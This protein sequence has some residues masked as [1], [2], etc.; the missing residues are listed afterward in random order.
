MLRLPPL[1]AV[2]LAP[3]PVIRLILVGSETARE[4]K[5]GGQDE[6]EIPDGGFHNCSFAAV[7]C[8]SVLHAKRTPAVSSILSIRRIAT[9]EQQVAGG[10]SGLRCTSPKN[11]SPSWTRIEPC[12]PRRRQS[13]SAFWRKSA[14]SLAA[15]GLQSAVGS[16]N[17]AQTISAL[18]GA[19]QRRP[20]PINRLIA[21]WTNS[22]A[23]R[24]A[25]H[26]CVPREGLSPPRRGAGC[27]H[28]RPC[29]LSTMRTS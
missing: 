10:P 18:R 21:S 17:L 15:Y 9:K 2:G 24:V 6:Q 13:F 7:K 22:V 1:R 14:P 20:H 26:R 11:G 23:L 5:R 28:R 16:S 27:L 25:G 4:R 3:L 12:A 29:D 8:L 19:A